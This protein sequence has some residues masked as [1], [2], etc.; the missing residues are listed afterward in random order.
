MARP[1][2]RDLLI[3]AATYHSKGLPDMWGDDNSIETDLRYIRLEPKT[4]LTRGISNQVDSDTTLYWDATFST[5]CEFEIE[6]KVNWNGREY[7]VVAIDEY[8]DRVKLHHLE[9]RLI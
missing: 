4:K 7:S 1:I 6:G 5:P 8:Y 2:R 9:V 3:H